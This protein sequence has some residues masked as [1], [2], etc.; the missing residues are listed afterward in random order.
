MIA[1]DTMIQWLDITREIS[2]IKQMDDFFQSY[3]DKLVTGSTSDEAIINLNNDNIKVHD[4]YGW[5]KVEYLKKRYISTNEWVKMIIDEIRISVTMTADSIIAA[6][7]PGDPVRGFHGEIKYPYKI[8]NVNMIS[9]E[10]MIRI[11][12]KPSVDNHDMF[13]H[14]IVIQAFHKP[15]YAYDIYTKSGFYNAGEFHMFCNNGENFN[16]HIL[17]K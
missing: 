8:R 4:L 15:E 12:N 5:T 3:S 2:V 13:F 6:Y 10:D 17:Y 1:G 16:T 11:T 7:Q 9:A 14:P